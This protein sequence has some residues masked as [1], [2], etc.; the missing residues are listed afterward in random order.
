LITMFVVLYRWK[1]KAGMEE[2]FVNAW[3]EVTKHIVE[4]YDSLGS[5]LH[6]GSDGIWYAYAQWKSEKQRSD[7]FLTTLKFDPRMKM[8]E[9]IEE[10]FPEIV[11]TVVSDQLID[12]S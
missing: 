7:A 9:A 10:S 1:T 11:L 4:N 8:R 5:K 2:Q 6:R 12:E 3:D